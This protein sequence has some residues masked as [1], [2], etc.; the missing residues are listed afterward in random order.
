MKG[1]STTGK[2]ARLVSESVNSEARGRVRDHLEGRRPNGLWLPRCREGDAPARHLAARR[3]SCCLSLHTNN[4]T[5]AI[6][7][8]L[9]SQSSP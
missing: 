5:T 4:N 1:E 2:G 3:R 7:L 9:H 6:S 8:C